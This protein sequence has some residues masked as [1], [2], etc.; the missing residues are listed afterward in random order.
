MQSARCL[1]DG[2]EYTATQLSQFAA[3]DRNALRGQL[4]CPYCGEPAYFRSA[5]PP[6]SGRRGRSSHFFSRPHGDSCDITRDYSDPWESADGD[7]TVAHWEER[8][9]KLIVHIRTAETALPGSETQDAETDEGQRTQSGGERTRQ[10]PNVVRGP[11]RL[12][13]QLVQWSSFKTSSVVIQL[14]DP[15]KTELP[16]HTAFVRFEHAHPERHTEHWHGFWG[17]V[18]PLTFWSMGSSYYANFGLSHR[19]FRISIHESHVPAILDRFRL[20]RIQ[21]IVGGYLLLFDIARIS[22]S[23]RFTADVNSVNHIGFLRVP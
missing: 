14:P 9:K 12:L 11:Q 19:D 7:S 4:V 15:N 13:E 23:G 2:R 6:D 21:D 3:Q 1:I 22:N 10:S 8:R 17:L 5:T 18:P 20:S 16:V